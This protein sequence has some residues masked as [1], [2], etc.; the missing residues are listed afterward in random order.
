YG[1]ELTDI[2]TLV[3]HET[4]GLSARADATSIFRNHFQTTAATARDGVTAQFDVTGDGTVMEGMEPPRMSH[5]ARPLNQ[6]SIG[7]ETGHAW[8]NYGGNDHQGPYITDGTGHVVARPNK[9]GWLPLSGNDVN[10]GP[11]DVPGIKLW[12][13]AEGREVIVGSWTTANYVGPW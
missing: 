12:A 1:D 3:V 9:G 5:H 2:H 10:N 8:G 6:S 4:S 11:D 13:M 7:S